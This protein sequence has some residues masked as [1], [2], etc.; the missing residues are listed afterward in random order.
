M[1]EVWVIDTD[2]LRIMLMGGRLYLVK[3][4]SVRVCVCAVRT[5]SLLTAFIVYTTD[6]YNKEAALAES[7]QLQHFRLCNRAGH[8]YFHPVVCSSSLFV[9][10]A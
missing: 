6:A 8:I 5:L 1:H 4:S 9:F 7:K 3:R 2:S 10:L